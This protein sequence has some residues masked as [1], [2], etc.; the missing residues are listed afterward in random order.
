MAA[1]IRLAPQPAGE[2][3]ELSA[4]APITVLVAAQHPMMR[5]GLR[6][7]LE[8]EQDIAV[9]A[10]TDGAESVLDQAGRAKANVVVLDRNA[11]DGS[12]IAMI[13][14]LRERAPKTQVV[15]LTADDPPTFVQQA[16]TVGALGLVEKDAADQELAPAIRAAA[17]GKRYVSPRL[18]SSLA[19]LQRTRRPRPLR[20]ALRPARGRRP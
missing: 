16:L 8:C 3:A 19:T 13:A 7:L 10:V 9:S 14:Q 17:L 1:Y 18:A 2:S 4:P 15:V 12:R 20:P 6:Q 5:H 11:S